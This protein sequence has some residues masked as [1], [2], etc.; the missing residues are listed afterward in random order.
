MERITGSPEAFPI[1]PGQM[2]FA[3]L[4]QE[5]LYYWHVYPDLFGNSVCK[6]RAFI[7][8]TT[9]YASVL[10]VVAFSMERYVAICHPFHNCA[11]SAFK[12]AIFA[13]LIIWLISV[14]FAIPLTNYRKPHSLT[15]SE[16]S[17]VCLLTT[18]RDLHSYLAGISVTFFFIPMTI[19]AVAYTRIAL[20][21]RSR[22]LS[23]AE[24]LKSR[25]N[26]GQQ[27]KTAMKVLAA[28]V[29][30][31]FICWAPFHVQRLVNYKISEGLKGPLYAFT[32]VLYYLSA[33]TNPILY[34]VMSKRYRLA[35]RE[36]FTGVKSVTHK[37]LTKLDKHLSQ[38]QP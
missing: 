32:G 21:I 19:L 29:I 7:S 11:L 14:V 35:F 24:S 31:F 30:A 1:S 6:L 3:G 33:T 17:R 12:R 25:A 34:N 23:A 5:L 4:P 15:F 22:I 26:R 9:T 38:Q 36:T 20:T 28:V 2:V 18:E 8:E 27:D 37:S 13:I 10:T 16:Y